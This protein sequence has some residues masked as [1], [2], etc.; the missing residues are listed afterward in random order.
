MPREQRSPHRWPIRQGRLVDSCDSSFG[1]LIVHGTL[2]KPYAACRCNCPHPLVHSDQVDV[3]FMHGKGRHPLAACPG[4]TPVPTCEPTH[5]A[6]ALFTPR[7]V[8]PP[9]AGAQSTILAA[10]LGEEVPAVFGAKCNHGQIIP[11]ALSQL[12][13]KHPR[14]LH[15][16]LVEAIASLWGQ[17]NRIVPLQPRRGAGL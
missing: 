10:Q 14:P 11:I 4:H 7:A 2:P 13:P 12:R 1:V 6:G 16:V 3:V 8:P 17:G 5:A 9:G 15:R